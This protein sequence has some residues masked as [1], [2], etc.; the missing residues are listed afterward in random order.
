MDI[1]QSTED[2]VDEGLKMSI[3]KR[4]ARSDDSSK[5]AFHQFYP[6]VSRSRGSVNCPS[7][8]S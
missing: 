3:G 5:I 1:F 7:L 8:P 2:L 6:K 4:L